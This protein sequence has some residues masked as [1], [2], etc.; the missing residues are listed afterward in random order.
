MGKT[1]AYLLPLALLCS[2]KKDQTEF[3]LT[4]ATQS[5]A[6]TLSCLVDGRVYVAYG[7]R[8][9]DFGSTC[10]EALEVRYKA[11]Q[12]RLTI[13]SVL[14]TAERDERL[15]ITCDSVFVPGVVAGAQQPFSYRSAGLGYTIDRLNY[16]TADRTRTRIMITRLDTV[17]HIISGSF[18]GYLK[19]LLLNPTTEKPAVLVSDGRFDIKYTK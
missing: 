2:C 11:K 1:Y 18:E 12:G 3:S 19:S 7:R 17:N 6:N 4:S 14:S 16:A 8:C 9:T 15:A 13:N 5:G 10:E